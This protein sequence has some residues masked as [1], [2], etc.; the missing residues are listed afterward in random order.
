M[1]SSWDMGRQFTGTLKTNML[2]NHGMK[3]TMVSSFEANRRK[4]RH[5][6][7]AGRLTDIGKAFISAYIELSD[8]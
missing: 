2:G 7:T 5:K 3:T 4:R 1:V 6:Q 8:V